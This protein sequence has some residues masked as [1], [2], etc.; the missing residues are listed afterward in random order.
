MGRQQGNEEIS[1]FKMFSDT[2]KENL[3]SQG[4]AFMQVVWKHF[5]PVR[6]QASFV[7]IFQ[8]IR[9]QGPSS[10]NGFKLAARTSFTCVWYFT[11]RLHRQAGQQWNEQFLWGLCF[12][13][14]SYIS[15]LA[16]AGWKK[17]IN[18]HSFCS[19][20]STTLKKK[21]NWIKTNLFSRFPNE[22]FHC[23]RPN[24]SQRLHLP[25]KAISAKTIKQ[26]NH[27]KLKSSTSANVFCDWIWNRPWPCKGTYLELSG[28][29]QAGSPAW[30]PCQ[31]ISCSVAEDTALSWVTSGEGQ[32]KVS[33]S[34]GS[35]P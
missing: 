22:L 26:R 28:H 21:C 17:C 18:L 1:G 20:L 6:K 13:S 24:T 29:W 9:F 35:G 12:S 25:L 2:Q 10:E 8:K 19:I 23:S 3:K 27:P 11:V 32:E 5:V 14:D 34:S 4:S 30:R 16:R 7:E 15:S 33:L 31:C